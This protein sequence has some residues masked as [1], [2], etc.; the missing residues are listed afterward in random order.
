MALE[1]LQT[2][3]ITF[4]SN[5]PNTPCPMNSTL[6]R[7]SLILC[8][9]SSAC[10][11]MGADTTPAADTSTTA[12]APAA[13]SSAAAVPTGSTP[14][15]RG[16]RG[17]GGAPATEAEK[18][19]MA[20]LADLPT[21][22]SGLDDGDYS[23]GPNYTP[24]PEQTPRDN[25]PHGKVIKFTMDSTDSKFY[26]GISRTAPGTV[27]PYKR[28]VSVYVPAQYVPGQP[29]PVI[30]SA[31]AYGLS[32]NQLP[33]ILDNMIADKRLPVIGAIMIA[34]GGGDGPGSE[35]G[36]EYDTVSAKYAEFVEA[37]VLPRVEK[38]TGITV[39]KNPDERMTLGGSSGG[40]VALTMAWYHPEWYHRVV[41]YSGT[42][43]NQQAS[44]DAPHGAWEY[45]AHFIPESPVKPLRL[46]LEAG[47]KDNGAATSASGFHNWVI[48]NMNMATVLKAKGYHYQFVFAKGA[49]HT[50]RRTIEQTLPQALEYVWKGY[51][52][53]GATAK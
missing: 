4:L 24:A 49:G 3:P 25:V 40:A 11:A 29:L 53:N 15:R 51:P 36:L 1:R 30:V 2:S 33:N 34:N 22:A 8:L 7:S 16:G 48:A 47:E 31:D 35:R 20:K 6:F 50:D 52:I 9:V 5:N 44:P 39:S 10:H 43:V 32:K 45:H 17:P 23:T 19:A 42:Y 21:Y 38:E 14:A 26:S 37:E 46:W 27:V 41:T 18:A 12:P 28:D 13:A